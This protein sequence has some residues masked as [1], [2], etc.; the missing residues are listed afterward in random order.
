[1]TT[2]TQ[3]ALRLLDR[4]RHYAG[5]EDTVDWEGFDRVESELRALLYA[6]EG[7]PS[8]A[9]WRQ[10]I[11]DYCHPNAIGDLPQRA[12][13]WIEQRAIALRD[14]EKEKGNG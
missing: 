14:A 13:A 7:E 12:S 11:V 1:M 5:N 4:L 8:A 3:D 9:N 6:K 2:D 10:A